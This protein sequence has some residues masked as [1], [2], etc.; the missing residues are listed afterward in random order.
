MRAVVVESK[1]AAAQVIDADEASMLQGDVQVD[2]LYSSFN[3]KDGLAIAGSGVARTF[4]LIPG[5]D[6]VGRVTSSSSEAWKPGDVVVANGD[7]LGEFKH[8]GF[9]TR[10]HLAADSLVRLPDS[11]SPDRAAAIGTAGFTAMIGVLKLSDAGLTPDSGDIL[12]TGAA[13]G[14]GS[15]AISLLAR[16]G[17]RVVAS[18]GR[19]DE[20]GDYLRGLGAADLIDRA[21]LAEA[22]RPLQSQRWAGAYDSVGSATLANILAQTNY[23]GTVVACGLAQGPDLPTTVMPFIL[24]D[25]TLTGA[26]SVDA[27]HEVRQRAW[28]A[29]G[30][31]LDLGLLD[32]MTE[33]ISLADTITLAP[34]ILA[35]RVRGRTVVDVNS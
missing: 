21:E 11:I 1:G 33:T 3:F 34:E 5:I 2:V 24:R 10:A 7:G 18:T 9:A 4:P 30:S 6:V 25:V 17:Y 13:G 27:P 16:R 8:G 20:Q 22:G 32:S 28:D 35:G 15:V 19:I 29:L 31:E 23:G 14:V 26:N 12:V